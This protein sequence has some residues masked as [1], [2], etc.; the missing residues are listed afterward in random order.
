MTEIVMLKGD[1]TLIKSEVLQPPHLEK[2]PYVF[3]PTSHNA[4]GTVR[5]NRLVDF[6]VYLVKPFPTRYY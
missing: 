5:T 2:H 4:G 6:A 1:V 3:S